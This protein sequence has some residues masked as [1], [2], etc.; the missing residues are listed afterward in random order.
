MRNKRGINLEEKEL[1]EI[2]QKVHK[3]AL[4]RL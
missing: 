3:F 1:K 2:K 4:V